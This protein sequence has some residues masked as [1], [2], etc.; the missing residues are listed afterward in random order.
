MDLLK[1]GGGK[2]VEGADVQL[3]CSSGIYTD[4]WGPGEMMGGCVGRYGGGGDDVFWWEF[5]S[6]QSG[7]RGRHPPPPLA[8][9]DATGQW[10]DGG[11][12]ACRTSVSARP[13]WTCFLPRSSQWHHFCQSCHN[14]ALWSRLGF[15]GRT[16]RKQYNK[17][18]I[19]MEMTWIGR[20]D[21]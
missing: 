8:A 7:L 4:M 2:G 11:W 1:G 5:T 17:V 12:P 10:G 20:R 21:G 9:V 14:P 13:L 19:S 3:G 18:Q 15:S 16:E 6:W